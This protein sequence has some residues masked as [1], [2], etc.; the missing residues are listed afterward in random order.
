VHCHLNVNSLKLD[1][2]FRFSAAID[3]TRDL[4]TLLAF[5]IPFKSDT[6]K[7]DSDVAFDIIGIQ[8]VDNDAGALVV[9]LL[10]DAAGTDLDSDVEDMSISAT[11][12]HGHI[13][14][15]AV[16]TIA[17]HQ[18]LSHMVTTD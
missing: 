18:G 8:A 13:I 17:L 15:N 11:A 3:G 7:P 14:G 1:E 10:V 12:F 9:F 5:R 2:D 6:G 4:A 16:N